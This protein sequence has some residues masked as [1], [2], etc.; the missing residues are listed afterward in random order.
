[1]GATYANSASETLEISVGGSAKQAFT[2][3]TDASSTIGEATT[4]INAAIA[5]NSTLAAAELVATNDGTNITITSTNGS[6]FRMNTVGAANVLGFNSVTATGVAVTAQTQS[7]LTAANTFNAQGSDQSTII[8]FS[9]IRTGDDDQTITIT[10]NNSAGAEQSQAIV[11][12][13]DGTAQSGRSIDDALAAINTALQQSNNATLK[14]VVAVKEISGGAEKIRFL[15]T[16]DFKVSVGSNSGTGLASGGAQGTVVT[17][18]QSSG[19]N[20]SDIS[21]QSQAKT[22]VTTLSTAVIVLGN[23]QA[24]V[25]KGQNNLNYAISLAQ[26]QLTNLAAAESRIRDADLAQEAANLTKAQILIQAG[27]AA[28]AQ[29]N[30]APQAILSLLKG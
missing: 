2:I 20:T 8:D 26:S 9:T 5:A 30:Q 3:T 10:A 24:V 19:G 23:A 4:A 12:R 14:Q 29:A 18:S 28:L 13:Q 1:M 11:L 27:T 15:S 21:T 7:A 25:G 6:R 17:S 16:V 22:A